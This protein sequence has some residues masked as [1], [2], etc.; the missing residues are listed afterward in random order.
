MI[1]QNA[2][3]ERANRRYRAFG[4]FLQ[5]V[6]LPDPL[7]W[8]AIEEAMPEFLGA[9]NRMNLKSIRSCLL[10]LAHLGV[11]QGRLE[12][13]ED[14]L[15][16]RIVRHLITRAPEVFQDSLRVY[17]EWLTRLKN[18]PSTVR[19]HLVSINPFLVW[20]AARGTR[21]PSEVTTHIF[22]EYEQFITWK[23]V[24]QS[25][26]N[27]LAFDLYGE[28]P[29]CNCR[30]GLDSTLKTRRYSHAT[31]AK[32]CQ[33]LRNFFSWAE[34]SGL[35]P[36][37]TSVA[38]RRDF[39]F[40]HYSPDVIERLAKYVL[41]PDAEPVE[42][43]V[44][45]LIIFHA[46]SVWE[47]AHALLP[48]V[49]TS[50]SET[51]G[52]SDAY[53]VVVPAHEPTR[54]NLSPGRPEPRVEFPASAATWLKP[55]LQ[56]YERWRIETLDNPS[57]KF[58]LVAPGRAR[59]DNPVCREFVRRVV[60]RASSRAGVGECNPKRLRATSA[61]FY[62]DSGVG[63]LTALGWSPSQ[64]FKF[65]WNERREVVHPRPT[66]STAK[67]DL[68]APAPSGGVSEVSTARRAERASEAEAQRGD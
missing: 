38:T 45:Y 20:C 50:S 49:D 56:R 11:A 24:C 21:S 53:Y 12:K 48:A 52:L 9:S 7:T 13:R 6:S 17:V 34:L 60:K 8:E 40:R 65:T 32:D 58:L 39:A 47:L 64:G 33:N 43:L 4:K 68:L 35:G 66:R 37:P 57:S 44:L 1:D 62:A 67:P 51:H 26:N 27:D 55:L 42:A 46:F 19:F 30:G 22:E 15:A 29:A 63:I 3:D 25:C 10:D 23:W 28:T 31:V 2:I 36:N 59:H 54:R 16:R 5:T 14:Y 18:S 41:S 61:T